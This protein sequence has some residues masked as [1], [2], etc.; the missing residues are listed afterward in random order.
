[1]Y[2]LQADPAEIHNLADLPSHAH[3]RRELE[4]TLLDLQTAQGL[5][6]ARDP[7]P[8][9]RGILPRLPDQKIR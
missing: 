6:P 1:L 2:D 8:L 5:D 3:L 4:Q 7:L 9:D